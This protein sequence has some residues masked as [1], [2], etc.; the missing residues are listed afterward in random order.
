MLFNRVDNKKLFGWMK[1]SASIKNKA[2]PQNLWVI[3]KT[4]G[5]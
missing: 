5:R 3:S 4:Y 2:R 1:R